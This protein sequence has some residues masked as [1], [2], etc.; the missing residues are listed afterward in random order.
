MLHRLA[1]ELEGRG[2]SQQVAS[3]AGPGELGDPIARAGIRVHA[4]GLSRAAPDPRKLLLLA[5]I[6]RETAPDVVQTWMYHADLVGGLAARLTRRGRIVWGLHNS[7]LDPSTTRR[8]THWTVAACA[9]LSKTVPHAIVSVAHASRDVHVAAGYDAKKFVVISNGFDVSEHRFDPVARAEL[10]GELAI[11][12]DAPV[13]GLVA[14]VDPQKDHA[15]FIRAAEILAARAG[16]ARFLL[17]GEGA[18]EQNRELLAAVERAGLRRR[19][20]LLGRRSD[21]VRVLSA[22][23]V[24]TLSSAYGE[25][26]PLV[27]G[28][29]M[30]CGVP[31]VVT[32][33]GDSAL[34]VGDTG[35]VVPPRDPA[36]LARR[37]E[38][39]VAL[40]HEG[41][42][43]L[44][45]SARQRIEGRFSMQ[46]TVAAYAEL[47]GRLAA[48]P[49]LPLRVA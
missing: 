37:W 11:P 26:L 9:R 38:D 14:R 27:I 36:A 33:V 46:A 21:V 48:S 32:D 45:H 15:T 47:Y 2:F 6:I 43:R 24:A 31:C 35:R 10:R 17:C 28:E 23:D 19:F 42:R 7:T 12:G 1:R 41:R 13:I 8:T 34:L 3:L 16:S 29:A 39:L 25:A 5:K 49:A 18:T 44:G 30:A 22:L 20:H 4:L 40:G